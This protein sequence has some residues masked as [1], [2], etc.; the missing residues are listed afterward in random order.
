M[1]AEKGRLLFSAHCSV[2]HR[3]GGEGGLIGPQL[4]GV[5][6]RGLARLSEDILDPSRNVDAHFRLTTLKKTDGSVAS[7]FVTSEGGEVV[8]LIDAAGQAHRVLKNEVS[9]REIASVSLM[10]PV[11]GEVLKPDEFRDLVGWL[12]LTSSTQ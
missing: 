7:G 11:F 4:D 1:D 3:I 9:D 8:T 6:T 12:L 10:P 5:G 2:C